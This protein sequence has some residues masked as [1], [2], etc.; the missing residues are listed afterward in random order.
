MKE[1]PDALRA[2]RKY[3]VTA[4]IFS[5]AINL[6]YLAGPLYMLQLYDRVINIASVITLRM[7]TIALLFAFSA[8]A[9]LDFVRSRVLTRASIRL[10]RLLAGRVLT[11]TMDGAIRGTPPTSQT[12]RDFDA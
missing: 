5:L 10:D 7:L 11:A 3:F 9:G 6:L 12:L 8:L 4:L 2:C 1:L